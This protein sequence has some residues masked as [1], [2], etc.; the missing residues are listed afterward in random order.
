MT[1]APATKDRRPPVI[2]LIGGI[3]AGKSTVARRLAEHG[4]RIIQGDAVG[5]EVLA[6]PSIIAEVARRFGDAVLNTE[7]AIDR[8]ALADIV[9][10]D[11]DARKW[12]EGLMHPRMRSVI[13]QRVAAASADPATRLVVLDAAILLEAGWDGP[14][15]RIVFVDAPDELRRQ[16]VA[17]ARGW[18]ADELTRREDAQWPLAE[19]RQR[20]RWIL[21]NS[22]DLADCYRATDA[23]FAKLMADVVGAAS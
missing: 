8:R 23:L 2:G 10:A 11:A 7:G 9:F 5:H 16:R 20:A 3:G 6:E 22:G 19:K 13:E 17:L 4:A 12:L 18:S 1:A 15:D 21:A 14:C